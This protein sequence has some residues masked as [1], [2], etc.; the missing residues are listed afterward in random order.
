[1]LAY[2]VVHTIDGKPE[3]RVE[4]PDWLVLELFQE[5]PGAINKVLSI[6]V[7]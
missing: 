7:K 6:D 1:M 2:E 4:S 5:K 3:K